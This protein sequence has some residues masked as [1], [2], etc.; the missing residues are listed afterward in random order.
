MSHLYLVYALDSKISTIQAHSRK[1]ALEIFA[2]HLLDD[3]TLYEHITD[4][5]VDD[6]LYA[7]FCHDDHGALY[8]FSKHNGI[9]Q[10]IEHLSEQEQ[11]RYINWWVDQNARQFWHDAPQFA[12]KY[13]SELNIARQ[14]ME[15]SNESYTPTFS[16]DFW[17][18]TIQKLIQQDDWYE[19]FGIVE[20]D[21]GKDGYQ[22]IYNFSD[23]HG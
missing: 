17:I 12:E 8:D 19:A 23:W 13:L 7:G 18:H 9:P 2:Q 14:L 11:K 21:V 20:I 5:S 4:F 6:G 10:R 15:Q 1:E 16:D 22:E 3:D